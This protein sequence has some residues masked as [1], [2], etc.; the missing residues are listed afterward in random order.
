M[1]FRRIKIASLCVL[2]L[3]TTPVFPQRREQG[4]RRKDLH[5]I[6]SSFK[7]LVDSERL[8]YLMIYAYHTFRGSRP[9]KPPSKVLFGYAVRTSDS[10]I[11]ADTPLTVLVDGQTLFLG[12]PVIKTCQAT[13]F[14]NRTQ[15]CHTYILTAEVFSKIANAQK[16]EMHLGNLQFEIPKTS[17]VSYLDLVNG[18]IPVGKKSV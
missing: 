10:P 8:D 3:A 12:E 11:Q 4:S 9:T 18:R 17:L 7:P 13:G 2:L 16:V 6:S 5:Y 14:I 15:K 1:R